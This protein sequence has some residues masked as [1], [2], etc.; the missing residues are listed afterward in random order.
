V[1]ELQSRFPAV[2]VQWIDAEMTSWYGV[3]AIAGLRGLRDLRS[4]AAGANAPAM[5]ASPRP[6]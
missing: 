3:R 1:R 5:R 6:A 2:R 4:G